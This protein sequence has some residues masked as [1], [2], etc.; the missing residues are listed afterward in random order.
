MHTLQVLVVFEFFWH[1]YKPLF[2]SSFS[3]CR[4]PCSEISL[5]ILKQRKKL[6]RSPGNGLIKH[7]RYVR[8][9]F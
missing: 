4:L 6:E 8:T 5:L 7:A 3:T 1:V 9:I 2:G